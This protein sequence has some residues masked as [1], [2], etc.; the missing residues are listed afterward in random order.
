LNNSLNTDL[1]KDVFIV[2]CLKK[3]YTWFKW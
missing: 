2:C 3:H 1:I